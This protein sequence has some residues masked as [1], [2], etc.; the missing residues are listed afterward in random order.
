MTPALLEEIGI[1]PYVEGWREGLRPD[2]DL[3]VSEWAEKRRVLPKTAA[4]PGP[5]RLNRTPYLREV[6]D[7][8]SVSSPVREVVVI[9]GTQLGFTEAGINWL[10]Y[11]IDVAPAPMM[12]VVPDLML[13]RDYSQTK[14]GPT[15]EENGGFGGKID[16]SNSRDK[17]NRTLY[18]EF[19]GGFMI[20]GGAKSAAF[21]RARSIR[22]LFL[23]DFDGYPVDVDGEGSPM[24]LAENRTDA[25]H[26]TR[27]IFKN[28][29]PVYA[30]GPADK[31][32]Q[33]SDQRHYYVP[34]P[35]CGHM[36][37]LE[38]EGMVYEHADYVLK[39]RVRFRC[40]GCGELIDEHHKQ[41][42][43]ERGEWRAENP[44]GLKR[45]YR[46]PSW[47]SPPGWLSWE[48]I[49]QEFLTAKKNRDSALLQQVI[50]T[51]FAEF[52]EEEGEKLE[53]HQLYERREDYGPATLPEHE[54]RPEVPM[55]ACILTAF[56]DVQG[57]RIEA[58][59]TAWG[60]GEESWAIEKR[61]I[62]GNT[63]ERGVWNRLAEFYDS[64][65]IHES[66]LTLKISLAGV[67]SGDNTATVYD[68]VR[69]RA[70]RIVATKGSK[71]RSREIIE[72]KIPNTTALSR[73]VQV[74]IMGVHQ[75]KNL[76]FDRL[77]LPEP[78]SGEAMHGFC[79]FPARP[80]YSP[81]HFEQLTAEKR[82][83]KYDHGHPYTVWELPSGKRNEALD[84][85]VGNLAM[86]KKLQMHYQ[87]D[88]RKRHAQVMEKAKE[89]KKE[90]PQEVPEP[91]PVKKT[92]KRRGGGFISG[93]K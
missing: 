20:L 12:I 90:K 67:D 72:S 88:L 29:S 25:F 52:W 69:P 66:G 43:L 54:G 57:D 42:M 68:F 61:I 2:P 34:C 19:P 56:A 76:L 65:Y 75:A 91:K 89:L 70:P 3:L 10:C 21:F 58:E 47:Y 6:M 5:Y 24:K 59:V 16:V 17:S 15:I 84:L 83:R 78:E 30:G 48:G 32:W 9:K 1:D 41:H 37:K 53:S 40:S 46:L 11:T 4:E 14:I 93:W 27:K 38:H 35:H 49:V 77:R 23:D 85:H 51:R 60:P 63:N 22:N 13:A 44:F 71:D 31:E 74:Q 64:A 82:V 86:I 87:L 28:T 36:Q 92:R 7:C 81:D 55:S 18:K 79:H 73:G 62:A 45:G 39:G 8:L 80:E 26:S 50:N 33:A